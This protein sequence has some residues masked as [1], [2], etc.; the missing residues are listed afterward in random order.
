MLDRVEGGLGESQ[1]WREREESMEQRARRIVEEGLIE[2]GWDAQRL[3]NE[4]KS[5]PVKAA[6]ARRLR[7]ETTVSLK[8]IAENLFMGTW[9]HVSNLL[10]PASLPARSVK[11]K[12][13]SESPCQVE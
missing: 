9:T 7:R 3:G 4:R 1:T 8:W 6:L 12:D 13:L 5:H 10:R 11:D 2:A